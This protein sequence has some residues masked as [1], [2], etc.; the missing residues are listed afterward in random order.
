MR[1]CN[2]IGWVSMWDISHFDVASCYNTMNDTSSFIVLLCSWHAH[3]AG[4]V[5]LALHTQQ[6]HPRLMIRYLEKGGV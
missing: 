6:C 2:G 1:D 3:R 5:R 4:I